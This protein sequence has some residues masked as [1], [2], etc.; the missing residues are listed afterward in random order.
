M[1]P[2]SHKVHP[3]AL[4]NLQFRKSLTMT[5]KLLME[6]KGILIINTWKK[7]NSVMS[8]IDALSHGNL[9]RRKYNHDDETLSLKT[10]LAEI[11]Q[12]QILLSQTYYHIVAIPL[13][14]IIH[15]QD[16]AISMVR[17]IQWI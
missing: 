4:L 11:L 8:S 10:E 6:N 3:N 15:L 14:F 9:L 12:F 16:Q 2:Q 13:R 7:K 17:E 5:C 1:T